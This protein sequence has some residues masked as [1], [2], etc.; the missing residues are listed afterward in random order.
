[1]DFELIVAESAK[2][3][4]AD[5]RADCEKLLRGGAD[6]GRL[7]LGVRRSVRL[8][9]LPKENS[10]P[11]LPLPRRRRRRRRCPCK[12]LKQKSKTTKT[13]AIPPSMAA[14]N[15]SV[16]PQSPTSAT[17]VVAASVESTIGIVGG[18]SD[19]LLLKRLTFTLR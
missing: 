8:D 16:S 4:G 18:L 11:Y 9:S 12:H 10:S 3:I 14:C 19:K 6:S 7:W 2:L 13:A 17:V 5:L 15:V 1:M